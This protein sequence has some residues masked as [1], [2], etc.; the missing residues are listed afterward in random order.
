VLKESG[1]TVARGGVKVERRQVDV[2]PLVESVLDDLRPVAETA[3]T[4]LTNQIPGTLTAHADAGMLKRVLQ[5]LVANAIKH[6]P[7]GEVTIG[8]APAA[9]GGIE[10]WVRDNGTG[11]PADR[12]KTI[13]E[14]D[15]SNAQREAAGGIGLSI[16]RTFVEAHGG[17]VNAESTEGAGSTF[18]FTLPAKQRR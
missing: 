11:I 17:T 3:G 16:V 9:H 15:A 4:R 5:N 1:T 2:W 13:F 6:T 12:L 7:R 14:S 10:C 18:R 8:A